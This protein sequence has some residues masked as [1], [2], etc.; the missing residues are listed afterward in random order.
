[1]ALLID[2]IDR[3]SKPEEFKQLKRIFPD[4]G[5]LQAKLEKIRTGYFK[6]YTRMNQRLTESQYLKKKLE[7]HIKTVLY[8]EDFDVCRLADKNII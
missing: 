6:K 1:M 8:Y 3:N 5:K 4:V 2:S 7:A